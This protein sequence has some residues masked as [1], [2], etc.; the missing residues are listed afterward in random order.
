MD[1]TRKLKQTKNNNNK[2]TKQTK[3][4]TTL[5]NER[6][7]YYTDLVLLETGFIYTGK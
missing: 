7:R 2:K 3:A 1:N 4:G 6:E 5:K